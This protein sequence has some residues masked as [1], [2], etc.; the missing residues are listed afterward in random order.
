MLLLG[1]GAWLAAFLTLALSKP[2]WDLLPVLA[3]L[4]FPWRFLGVVALGFSF[5]GAGAVAS[6][7]GASRL[8]N[9][10]A[11]GVA[12]AL[13]AVAMGS[14]WSRFAPKAMHV[15]ED[16]VLANEY[17]IA[18]MRHGLFDFL[19]RGVDLQRFPAQPPRYPRPA[20]TTEAPGV[21]IDD[22]KKSSNR[23]DFSVVVTGSPA[24]VRVEVFRFPGWT[25]LVDQE[26]VPMAH[27]DDPLGRIH[28]DVP[29]GEHRVRVVFRDTAVRRFSNRLSALAGLGIALWAFLAVRGVPMRRSATAR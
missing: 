5:A 10:L 24:R 11:W 1:I 2:I 28:V 4:Q 25:V 7:S 6:W 15:I 3:I 22:V 12:A 9:W 19:P 13:A 26:V 20:V 17:E 21:Q 16:R 29:A 23:V 18:R 14:S 8:P 27:V